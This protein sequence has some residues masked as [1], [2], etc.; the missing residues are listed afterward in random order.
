MAEELSPIRGFDMLNGQHHAPM[1]PEPSEA[2]LKADHT[3]VTVKNTAMAQNHIVIDRFNVGH[4]LRPGET[5]EM[6]MVNSEIENFL[7]QRRPGRFY[8]EIDPLSPQGRPKPPHPIEIVG[9]SVKPS[10]DEQLETA[11]VEAK[12]QSEA[13]Q[14]PLRKAAR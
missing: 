12:R 11:A 13:R 7:E 5:R 1:R 10:Q 4:E 8:P 2:R 9:Y 14:Q 6:D 3:R